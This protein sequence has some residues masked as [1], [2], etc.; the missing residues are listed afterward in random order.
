M[1]DEQVARWQD[2]L[3]REFPRGM[4]VA[5]E[6]GD[7]NYI[8][9]RVIVLHMEGLDPVVWFPVFAGSDKTFGP[10]KVTA[11]EQIRSSPRAVRVWLDTVRQ[12]MVWSDTLDPQVVREME[13]ERLR[14]FE[15]APH[16]GDIYDREDT[17]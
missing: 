13:P 17:T 10:L 1:T 2:K 9:P 3:D 6:R 7:V 12:P 15:L 16:G 4:A 5:F 8:V 11:Y 14:L